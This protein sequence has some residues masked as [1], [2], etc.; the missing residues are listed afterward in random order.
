M[1]VADLSAVLVSGCMFLGALRHLLTG[2][3]SDTETLLRMATLMH[4]GQSILVLTLYRSSSSALLMRLVSSWLLL[5]LWLPT[6]PSCLLLAGP[7]KWQYRTASC[8]ANLGIAATL[9]T[10]APLHNQDCALE[11]HYTKD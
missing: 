10:E 9:Y 11:A 7:L 8:E 1:C 6:P 5:L 2:P 3:V 4:F